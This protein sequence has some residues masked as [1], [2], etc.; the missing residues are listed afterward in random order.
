MVATPQAAAEPLDPLPCAWRFMSDGEKLNAAFP[1]TNAAYWVLPYALGPRDTIELSGAF[2]AA[3]YFSLNTYGT[4]LDTIDTLRDNQISADPGSRNPF[5]EADAPTPPPQ[6]R[7]WQATLVPGPADHGRNEI[8]AL[9]PGTAPVGFL[10]IRIYVPD[11]PASLS[12]GAALP[13][14]TYRLG[15]STV[16]V[17]PCSR[18]LDPGAHSGPL[19]DAARMGVNQAIEGAAA[20]AIPGNSPEARF[21]NPSSTSGLFPNGDNK[22]IG[23]A[24]TY[25]PGRIVVVRGKAPVFPDTRNGAPPTDPDQQVRYWSMCQ[26]DLVSPYPVVACAADYQTRV[27][28]DGYYTYVV[29]APVDL[30]PALDPTVTV[31]PW[32]ST[33]VPKKVL[34]LRNMLPTKDF[35]PMSIQASQASDSDPSVSMGDF[36]PIATYCAATTFADHG[37]RSCFSEE[38]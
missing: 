35:Y 19:A 23:A 36:Y 38:Q 26:N 2:P 31:L 37:Y 25:Q 22:Y 33:D 6:G 32:G 21:V 34:I 28:T 8:Q 11:D 24:L 1:D 7:S 20:G 27:D 13:D 9:T 17:Q 29:A 3:R 12:G 30:P 4:D 15:G 10:I 18:T 14:V 16:P 5:A